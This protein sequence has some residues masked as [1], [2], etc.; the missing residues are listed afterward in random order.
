[1]VLGQRGT[2]PLA[3]GR[4]PHC[5]GC[6]FDR[7]TARRYITAAVEL[8]VDRS[9]DEEQL[10][11]ELTGQVCERVRPCRR[12]PYGSHVPGREEPTLEPTI[13]SHKLR[14]RLTPFLVLLI[15]SSLTCKFAT[16]GSLAGILWTIEIPLRIRRLGVRVP[17]S[18]PTEFA[19][20]VGFTEA[21]LIT[22]IFVDADARRGVSRLVALAGC[23]SR[24]STVHIRGVEVHVGRTSVGDR[25]DDVIGGCRT[26]RN[27]SVGGHGRTTCECIRR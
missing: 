2:P 26:G 12:A 3:E 8:G 16:T 6:G 24:L 17:P 13:G 27:G 25:N 18:A 10:T 5:L 7:K 21:E 20:R 4:G 9:G 14:G 15:P 1:V 23:S 19:S 11:G 22:T